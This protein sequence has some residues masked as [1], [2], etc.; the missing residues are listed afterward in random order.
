[1]IGPD[2]RQ[3]I[4]DARA[5]PWRRIC[6]LDLKGPQGTFKGTGWLAGPATVVTAGHCVHFA[7]FF[8]GW[9]DRI[10][11]AA[12]R[13]G[14]DLP[15]GSIESDHF[16]TLNLW[17]D[18]QT[19]DY[20]IAAVHLSEPLGLRTGSFPMDARAD[21]D[22]VGRLVNVSGYPTD[23]EL[24]TV[25]YHHAN[26]VMQVT[27]RRLFYEIDTVSGQSGAPVWIQ[28]GP[29]GPPVCV[30]LHAYGIPGTPI[31]LHI[32]ANSAPRFDDAVLAI[33]RD[34]VRADCDRL[35]LAVPVS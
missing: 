14:D 32:T 9:A 29:G 6:Q 11:V 27:P 22:L 28:D 7:P 34:W 3:R 10:A 1:M 20:D 5:D 15:F 8:D 19:A 21:A 33:L 13:S 16:S 17:I 12:G 25:Q 4:P 26:R 31:D 30:G 18:G 35:G 23:K 24:A 2:E